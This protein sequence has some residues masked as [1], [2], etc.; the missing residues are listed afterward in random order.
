L[1]R[2]ESRNDWQEMNYKIDQEYLKEKLENGNYLFYFPRLQLTFEANKTVALILKELSNGGITNPSSSEMEIYK[3]LNNLNE[4]NYGTNEGCSN[5]DIFNPTDLTLC[6]TNKCNLRCIYCYADGGKSSGTISKNIAETAINYIV[7]NAISN[8]KS[9]I[10]LSL[11]GGGEPTQELGLI[12]DLSDYFNK[13][14]SDNKLVGSISIGTNG[15]MN[16]EGRKFIIDYCDHVTVSLDGLESIHNLQRPSYLGLKNSFKEVCKTLEQLS[17]FNIKHGVRV[18]VTKYNVN[19]LTELVNFLSE[20]YNTP[21][22]QF[23]PVALVGRGK[24]R[25]DIR[26]DQKLFTQKYL[27]AEEFSKTEKIKVKY[28]GFKAKPFGRFCN[29]SAPNFAVTPEGYL[30]SCL[31]VLRKEDPR[32]TLFFYGQYDSDSKKFVV[33]HDKIN[34][35]QQFIVDNYR[36]CDKCLAKYHCLGDCPGKRALFGYPFENTAHRC[37]INISLLKADLLNKI[38]NSKELIV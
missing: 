19:Y 29:V 31:E 26:V 9:N 24:G 38:Y 14:T 10:N 23:E 2:N 18:T 12:R 34:N 27:E 17:R 25:N 5:D 20:S 30:T 21:V 28:S 11:H 22:V 33:D 3:L 1:A 37:K 6:I 13:T 32:S 7:E 8:N 4:Y 35:L 16:D 36:N 15:V